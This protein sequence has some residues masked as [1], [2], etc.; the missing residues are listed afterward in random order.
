MFGIAGCQRDD[1]ISPFTPLF[2][3]AM[4]FNNLLE[5][6]APINKRFKFPCLDQ[7][8]EKKQIFEFLAITRVDMDVDVN[9][10]RLEHF[11]SLLRGKLSNG[12]ESNIV[13]FAALREILL[14][15]IDTPTCP[16]GFDQF[17]IR[18]AAYAGYISPKVTTGKL[19]SVCPTA[20]DAP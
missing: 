8:F 15:V 6:V 20:P 18:A 4:R 10:A 14:G 17:Q 7:F 12:V 1:N 5:R 2:D 3:I 11:F 16:Q 9:P 13:C 19:D